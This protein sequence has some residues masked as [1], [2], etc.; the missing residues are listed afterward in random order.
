[1]KNKKALVFGETKGFNKTDTQNNFKSF[2][3]SRQ[4]LAERKVKYVT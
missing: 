3:V 4:Y 2:Q 1:M